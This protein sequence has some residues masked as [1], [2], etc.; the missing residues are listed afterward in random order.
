MQ[1]K[2]VLQKVCGGD[3]GV[4]VKD[5]MDWSGVVAHA[6]NPS[7]VGGGGGWITRLGAQDQPGQ[8]GETPVLLKT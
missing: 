8:Y 1:G 2:Q 3:G 4:G 5:L 6:C 7:T